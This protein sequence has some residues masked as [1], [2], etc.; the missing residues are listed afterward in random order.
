MISDNILTPIG[1]T[2]KTH[3]VN[4][5]INAVVD[6]PSE[7]DVLSC[8]IMKVD[9]INV[10]FFIESWRS[11]GP[12]AVLIK[13]DHI[14]DQAQAEAFCGKEL[15]ALTDELPR[16]E[17]PADFADGL[18]ASDLIG[19][20]VLDNGSEIGSVEDFDDSTENLLLNVAAPDGRH[21]LIP[22]ADD[23]V[24][25]TDTEN[26]HLDMNLPQGLLNYGI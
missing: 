18:Y 6:D 4:G 22:L 8:L 24:L 5:E 13:F 26:R 17:D 7:L 11:R 9:G 15:M 10:P 2:V 16:S 20:T 1:H 12:E 21:F 3:G 25:E 19:W 14:A 23:L